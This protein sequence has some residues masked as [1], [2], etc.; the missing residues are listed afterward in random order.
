MRIA[1]ISKCMTMLLLG[2]L[3]EDGKLDL[4]KPISTYLNKDIWPEKYFQKKKFDITLR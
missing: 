4:D 2:K 1:S 3:L